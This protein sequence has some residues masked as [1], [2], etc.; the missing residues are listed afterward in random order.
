M[1]TCTFTQKSYNTAGKM[2]EVI[3]DVTMS[4]SYAT[5]GDAATP[6]LFG[7]NEI[8]IADIKGAPSGIL[9]EYVLV[10]PQS[11]P[12]TA[13]TVKAWFPTGGSQNAPTTLIFP[14]VPA[15]SV[16]V[17]ALSA[18]ATL[19]PGI[20]AEVGSGAN[21]SSVVGRITLRGY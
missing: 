19:T 12:T 3:G 21:L 17:T 6:A 16:T 8:L 15:G 1:G 13:N 2:R 11:G 5:G 14:V 20:A 9:L 10:S 18:N 7:L 4:S